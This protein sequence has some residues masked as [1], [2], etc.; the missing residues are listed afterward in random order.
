M[1]VTVE[2]AK[3][4][5]CRAVPLVLMPKASSALVA[6]KQEMQWQATTCVGPDCMAWRW[7]SGDEEVGA[8]GER[9]YCGYVAR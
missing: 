9:G 2:R 3:T 4:K 1:I 6:G 5:Q 8:Q 7:E